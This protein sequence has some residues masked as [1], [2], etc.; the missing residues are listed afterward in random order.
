MD[1]LLYTKLSNERAP[2]FNIVTDIVERDG[3]R[4]VIKRP[5][6]E[7]A[8]AHI[9][10]CYEKYLGLKETFEGTIFE[11]NETRLVDGCLECEYVEGDHLNKEDGASFVEEIKKAYMSKAKTFELSPEFIEVFGEV[12]LSGSVLAA[13]F[14]DIDLL[15]ENIIVRENKWVVI[16]YEWTFDFLVPINYIFYRAEKFSDLDK[17]LFAI[18]NDEARVYQEMEA[19]F[20][21]EYCFKGVK[22]LHELRELIADESEGQ[23]TDFTIA[24][25]DYQIKQ[26]R[27][28]IQLKDNHIKNIEEI[29]RL[30]QEALD[31]IRNSTGYKILAKIHDTKLRLKGIE[32]EEAKAKKEKKAQDKAIAKNAK[33]KKGA[34]PSVAVHIHLFYEDLL[35]EF[36]SYLENMPFTFDLYI[37]CQ[38]SADVAKIKS[39]LKNIKQIKTIDIRPLPNR[40]RDLAPLYVKFAPEILAHDYF[41]HV[42]TKKSL[43]SG[44]EKGLWR[45]YCLELLLGSKDKIEYIFD[46]FENK[47]VGLVYPDIHEEIPTIAYSWLKNESIARD[48]LKEYGIFDLPTV[49]NYPAGSFFWAR[50]D[51]LRPLLEKGYTYEDFPREQGQTDGTLAHALER[52]LPFVS[53]NQGYDDA[54]LYLKEDDTRINKSLRPFN[55][56]FKLDKELLAM[57]LGNYDVVSFDIF[58]TLM[59]RAVLDPEDVYRIVGNVIKERYNKTVDFVSIRKKAEAEATKNYGPYTNIDQIYLEISKDKTIGDYAPNIKQIE[60]D[61]EYKLCMPRKDMVDVYNIVR[62]MGKPVILVSDMYL[63]KPQIVAMLHKCGIG[64]Y[65]ELF[66]SCEVGAR[67]DDGSMWDMVLDGIDPSR[68]IHVGDNFCSDSQVLMDR[69]IASNI[70]LSP[71][72]MLELSKFS[73]LANEAKECNDSDTLPK[74][75]EM[76]ALANSIYLGAALNGG[77]FNSPFAFDEN[78]EIRF[79]TM[80]DLGYTSMG[81]LLTS[82]IAKLYEE[83]VK[84]GE[85][86]LLLSREGYMLEKL[87]KAYAGPNPKEKLDAVYF[88]TSRRASGLPTIENEEDLREVAYERYEGSLSNLLKARLGLEFKKGE[89]DLVFHEDTPFESLQKALEPYRDELAEKIKKEKNAYLV[90]IKNIIGDAD[91]ISVVDV[92]FSGTIQYFLIKLTSKNIGGH[93]LCLHSN[94]PAS[95]GGRAEAIYEIDDPTKFNDSK[96]FKYQLFLENALSAPFGQLICFNMKDGKPEPMYKDDDALSEEIKLMQKGIID[97]AATVGAIYKDMSKALRPTP[98]LVEDVFYDIIAS[99]TLTKELADYLSVEDDYCKGGVQHFDVAT[100]T[101]KVN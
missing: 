41:L 93:Y 63:K 27:E 43:Y 1:K 47:N 49:F 54:I 58:D 76:V 34:G 20:Q 50:T 44:V 38:E 10:A 82:F 65:D 99:G 101:W 75:K 91:K 25:R 11:V 84:S 45:R 32:T 66:L 33:A 83:G 2:K 71:K 16:D 77:I 57:K 94:K 3:K 67:K 98:G 55:N 24:R 74:N 37:S 64:N 26:L 89:V 51:A 23:T 5:Y 9:E 17:E 69:G 14:I 61:T 92:G 80:Y 88:L 72:A 19:H 48:I 68:F 8:A 52:V 59:T 90:Y 86:L 96:I 7:L 73:Y 97:Y 18:S 12:K 39:G 40:G 13:S 4:V 36:A 62:K 21:Y 30:Q 70:I 81:P 35:E 46:L 100:N 56:V 53:R 60:I 6:D 29:N 79:K 31:E 15:F 28:Q 42:H 85:K 22:N 87:I 78:G 95:I